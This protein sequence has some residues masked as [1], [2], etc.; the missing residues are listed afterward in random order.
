MTCVPAGRMVDERNVTGEWF[1]SKG[2][3]T[4]HGYT[5]RRFPAAF[6]RMSEAGLRAWKFCAIAFPDCSS[7]VEMGPH[8]LTV[9][10]A[11]PDWSRVLIANSHRLPV[12]PGMR[13]HARAPRTRA[14]TLSGSARP[15]CNGRIGRAMYGIESYAVCRPYGLTVTLS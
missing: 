5:E 13:I 4:A 8:F 15:V 12:S 6:Q 3:R 14:S 2:E 7:G 10:G 11:A 9:A 1:G